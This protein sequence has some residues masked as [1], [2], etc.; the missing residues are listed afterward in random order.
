LVFVN[1]KYSIL[2]TC[3]SELQEKHPLLQHP[4]K[5]S[6]FLVAAFVVKKEPQAVESAHGLD[7]IGLTGLVDTPLPTI[8]VKI[9]VAP[10]GC[11][12]GKRGHEV[13]STPCPKDK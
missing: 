4:N 7:S 13:L 3:N 2:G 1:S 8:I 5:K 11:L 9:V 6:R 10:G 12:F